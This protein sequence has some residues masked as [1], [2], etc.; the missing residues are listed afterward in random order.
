MVQNKDFLPQDMQERIRTVVQENSLSDTD[1]VL[2]DVLLVVSRDMVLSEDT[3]RTIAVFLGVSEI[4]VWKKIAS[5]PLFA[6]TTDS[7]VAVQ[8]CGDAL[9]CMRGGAELLS[10]ARRAAEGAPVSVNVCQTQCLGRCD[11]APVMRI[12]GVDYVN[13]DQ[14]AIKKVLKDMQTDA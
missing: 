7:R 12:R 9:C 11:K 8:V 4:L 14:E 3:V 2:F 1:K 6:H 10:S 13:M 5:S